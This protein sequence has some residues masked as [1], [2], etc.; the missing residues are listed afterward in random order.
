MVRSFSPFGYE[1][2]MVTVEVDLR[3]GIP[4]VDVVGL[5]DGSVAA[6]RERVRSAI[7]N[8]G[9]EF[10]SERVLISLSPADLKK[11]GGMFNLAVAL[12]ILSEKDSLKTEDVLVIGEL[13]LHGEVLPVRGIYAAL[14][15]ASSQGIKYAIIPYTENFDF[16]SIPEGI[17]VCRVTNLRQAY[18]ALKSNCSPEHFSYKRE[19]HGNG[20]K[21]EFDKISEEGSLDEINGNNGLKYAMAVAVA[22]RHNILAYGRPGCGKTLVLQKMP[23]L[24]PKLTED[25]VPAVDRIYS[26]AG[27]GGCIVNH[28]RPFRMPHQTATIEGMCGGGHNCAPGEISLAHNGVLF[29]DE[30][31]EFRSSVL[32][33]LRVPIESGQITMSRAGRSTTYPARFQLAMATSPCPCGNLG[34]NDRMCLCS[35]KSIEQ[36]WKKMSGP[37]IDR[38]GIRIDCN[39]DNKTESL[40]LEE[41]RKMVKRAWERQYKRQGKLN[42]DLNPKEVHDYIELSPVAK[43]HLDEVELSPRG[44]VQVM[45]IARTLADMADEELDT[46]QVSD[47][48]EAVNLHAS[49]PGEVLQ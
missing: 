18:E 39:N 5:A 4:A 25:E 46:V 9:F 42:E 13:S 21:V 24:L 23:Q 1:S 15:T 40:T 3:R 38:I 16:D 36:Y 26:I 30:A 17:S 49:T 2:S 35:A 22:G 12:G 29:L 28:T 19:S 41:M 43:S 14:Q 44:I 33:M 47:V 34:T 27:L 7:M 37:L 20:F 8:S 10:P 45:K 32:Q 6:S 48:I 31:M 11:E